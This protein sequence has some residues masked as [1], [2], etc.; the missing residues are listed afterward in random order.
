MAVFALRSVRVNFRPLVRDQIDPASAGNVDKPGR[1]QGGEIDPL[2]V[3]GSIDKNE[4]RPLIE[5]DLRQFGVPGHRIGV[6]WRREL[7]PYALSPDALGKVLERIIDRAH[8]KFPIAHG[9][10]EIICLL[11]GRFTTAREYENTDERE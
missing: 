6:R 3:T 4:I 11:N 7:Y 2:G 5:Q 1:W 9:R 10:L 8:K